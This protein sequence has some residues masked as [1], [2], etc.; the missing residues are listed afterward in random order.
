[1]AT[2]IIKAWID[3]AI[4]EIEVEDIISPELPPSVEERLDVL[5]DKPIITDGNFLVGNGTTEMEEMTPEQTLEH[6]NGASVM[7]MTTAEFEAMGDDET[8]ANTVYLMTDDDTRIDWNQNDETADDYIKNRT[9]YTEQAALIL[10]TSVTFD[11]NGEYSYGTAIPLTIGKTYIVKWNGVEYKCVAQDASSVVDGAIG[12]GNGTAFGL[13]SNNEPFVVASMPSNSITGIMSLDGSTEARVSVTDSEI[14]H[15]LDNKYLDLAWLPCMVKTAGETLFDETV[16]LASSGIALFE[17]IPF[18][19]TP[20]KTYTVTWDGVEY[21][22]V[23][24]HT[25]LTEGI[26]DG[27]LQVDYIGNVSI[28]SIGDENSGEPFVL[29][30]VENTLFYIDNETIKGADVTVKV[31]EVG[32]KPNKMPEEYLPDNAITEEKLS[33]KG[34]LTSYTETDP[35]V[36]DWA[37]AATKPVY[38]ASEVGA[39]AKGT[40][41]SEVS[42]HN[43][44]TSAHS[45]IRDLIESNKTLIEELQTEIDGKIVDSALSTTSENPV[46]NKV[47]TLE[48]NKKPGKIVTGKYFSSVIAGDGA[49]I[50]NSYNTNTAIGKYSHAEGY[51][52]DSIG[53]YS[54]AEGQSSRA[55]GSS[56]HAEGYNS[57]AGGI[58]SHAEGYNSNANGYSSH[59]EGD[60]S[61]AEGSNSHAEGGSTYAE[62]HCSHAEGR[63]RHLERIITGAANTT[64]YT[65]DSISHLIVGASICYSVNNGI[66]TTAKIKAI[67][68]NNLTITVSKTLSTETDLNNQGVIIYTE[69]MAC[70]NYSHS[71]GLGTIAAVRSQHTQGEYNIV[72]PNYNVNNNGLRGKY[73]HIIGNGTE[74]TSRSNAH[75]IDWSG[76]AWFAGD[77]YVGSTS[78]TNKDDGSKKIVAAPTDVAAGDLL[79][80]DGTN[81][82]RISKADLIA[83]IIAALPSAE[84]ASF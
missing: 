53:D 81:W 17:E 24:K 54:H 47:I 1:M 15:K 5:E 45:D 31:A 39:D 84:E 30:T 3:G 35:T 71:E 78:G 74:D 4:Q 51:H 68:E 19:I 82:V 8:N 50:F 44:S 58:Y 13:P 37:K 48:L 42:A 73:A 67:D 34:Y 77:V 66:Y 29:Y 22:C 60:Y 40:A 65:I 46:Q 70:G 10:E 55:E 2:K 6:I 69:G 28:T 33:E 52:S 59:A 56:S 83:E 26:Q 21:E 14:I 18:T 11:E 49:E 20:G 27:S 16:H 25:E 62:G 41:S 36:P 12:L 79:T 80:Y 43:A 38:T 57:K 76:N 64:I 75:T 61:Y 72:D 23:A 9:H 63:G 7:T 32:L